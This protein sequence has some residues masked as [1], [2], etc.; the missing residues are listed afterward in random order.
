[1][2]LWLL[3][4]GFPGRIEKSLVSPNYVISDTETGQLLEVRYGT[5]VR[6][7]VEQPYNPTILEARGG[8]YQRVVE[9][10]TDGWI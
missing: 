8:K 3:A 1:M 4:C 2:I 10:T 5:G 9:I 7:E 6:G